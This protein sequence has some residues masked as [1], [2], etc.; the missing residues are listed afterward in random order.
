MKKYILALSLLIMLSFKGF[1]QNAVNPVYEK[2]YAPGIQLGY[3]TDFESDG[4]YYWSLE[5]THG[6][7][8][9]NGLF[10]GGGLGLQTDPEGTKNRKAE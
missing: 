8:F 3:A 1:S 6:Y 4:E 7:N 2:G 9:G 5:T 10:L